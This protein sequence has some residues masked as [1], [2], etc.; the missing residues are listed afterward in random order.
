[1]KTSAALLKFYMAYNE[2]LETEDD[3][4]FCGYGLCANAWD[5]YVDEHD[6]GDSILEEMH[7]QFIEAGLDEQ[8][9]FNE[10]S[11]DYRAEKHAGTCHHNI[12]RIG[13]VKARIAEAISG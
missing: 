6:L 2:W 7:A 9:P 3:T 8:L 13:W 4:F 5:F 1:M 10:D 11:A 12:L